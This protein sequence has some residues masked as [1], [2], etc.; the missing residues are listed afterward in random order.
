MLFCNHVRFSARQLKSEQ[1]QATA[2]FKAI[3]AARHRHHE[4]KKRIKMAS[5]TRSVWKNPSYLQSSFG[6][7]MFFCS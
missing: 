3:D 4:E 1:A 2:T 6:I 7:F 5:K